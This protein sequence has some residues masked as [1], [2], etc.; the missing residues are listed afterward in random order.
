MAHAI[1]FALSASLNKAQVGEPTM[2]LS[3]DNPDMGATLI[4]VPKEITDFVLRL[5]SV[6]KRICKIGIIDRH[7]VDKHAHSYEIIVLL[8]PQNREA[9]LVLI[10]EYL[11]WKSSNSIMENAEIFFCYDENTFNSEKPCWYEE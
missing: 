5:K 9:R 11:N 3:S 8:T 7:E 1:N 10:D 2:I 4:S 6:E